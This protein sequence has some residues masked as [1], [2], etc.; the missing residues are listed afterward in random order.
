MAQDRQAFD[1]VALNHVGD[2]RSNT[3]QTGPGAFMTN[4]RWWEYK[5]GALSC[6]PP[7][8]DLLTEDLSRL[9]VSNSGSSEE[10]VGG[11]R[12][13]QGVGFFS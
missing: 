6:R 11:F 4:T 9:G 7:L 1:G 8:K 2:R 13:R 12:L 3:V 5:P 10:I